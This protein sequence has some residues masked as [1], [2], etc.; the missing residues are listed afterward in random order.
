M[1][2]HCE[3]IDRPAQPVLSIRARTSVQD[4]PQALGKAYGA[5]MQYLGELGVPPAGAP[6]VAYFNMDMQDLDIE[7]GIPVMQPLSGRGEVQASAIPAGKSATILHTGP[8]PEVEAAY[9]ALSAWVT[10][11]RY[12]T[13]GVSY[14]F[15][16]N[17]PEQTPQQELQTQILF[18][19][20]N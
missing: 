6:F 18:P 10:E 19:L 20:T 12:T 14:E 8:Y 7:I 4:L 15:Y 17:D 9:K 13:T 11:N 16:L 2:Y 5:I 1:T 3:T